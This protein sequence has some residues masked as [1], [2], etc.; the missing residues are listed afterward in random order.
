M[1]YTHLGR[2][3]ML[4]ALGALNTH[5]GL[6]QA[7]AP[8]ATTGE[9]V[10]DTFDETAHPFNNGD[11]VVLS[12]L[13]GGS[14]LVAGLPYFVVND[15]ANSFQIALVPGGAAVD[16]G[17][18]VTAVNVTRLQELAGGSPAYARKAITWSA[19]ALGTMDSSNAPVFDVQAGD[20]VDYVG[21]YSASSGGT[22]YAIDQVTQETFGG[23]GTYTLTDA[24]LDLLA[25]LP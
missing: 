22:L 21:F 20:I 5:A 17:T 16:F 19:A 8:V 2:N 10:D 6:L 1:P 12:G 18:D 11:L 3:A 24:D 7:D 25:A 4:D 23:Q 15:A 14:G 9:T 13:S